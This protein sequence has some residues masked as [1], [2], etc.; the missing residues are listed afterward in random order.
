M[1]NL[2]LFRRKALSNRLEALVLLLNIWW[3]FVIDNKQTL[4]LQGCLWIGM[5]ESTKP[6]NR[7]TLLGV[8]RWPLGSNINERKLCRFE[9]REWGWRRSNYERKPKYFKW[10]Y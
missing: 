9:K 3:F 4:M 6:I 8:Q 10:N 2:F 7:I 1:P 5:R